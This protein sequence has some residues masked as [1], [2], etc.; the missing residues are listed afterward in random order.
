MYASGIA[1][2]VLICEI[3]IQYTY[4]VGKYIYIYIYLFA[5]ALETHRKASLW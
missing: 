2:W 3:F 4:I 5:R 1:D